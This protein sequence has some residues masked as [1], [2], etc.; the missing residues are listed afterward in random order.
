MKIKLY[1]EWAFIPKGFGYNEAFCVNETSRK[2]AIKVFK[3]KQFAYDLPPF[4][5]LKLIRTFLRFYDNDGFCVRCKI[6][7]VWYKVK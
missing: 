7:K 2:K 4:Y 5:N 1:H 3:E 6:L